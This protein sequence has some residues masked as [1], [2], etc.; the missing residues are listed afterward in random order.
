MYYKYDYKFITNII[1]QIKLIWNYSSLNLAF[2]IILYSEG[3]DEE[4]RK[5]MIMKTFLIIIRQ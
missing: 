4:R 5:S 2:T 3:I 1:H